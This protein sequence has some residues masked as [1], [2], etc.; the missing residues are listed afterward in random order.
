MKNIKEK[1]YKNFIYP[2]YQ[3]KYGFKVLKTLRHITNTQ[4]LSQEKLLEYQYN[5][6]LKL[7]THAY[8]NVP[9]YKDLMEKIKLEPENIKSLEDLK[10]FPILTKKI[11]REN[12]KKLFSKDI[13]N[14]TTIEASTGGTTGEPLK[15]IRD[16][17]T[18]IWTESCLLRG[19]SW[20]KYK[21]GDAVINFMSAGKPSFLGKIRGRLINNYYFPAFE[22]E[23]ALLKYAKDIKNIKP[24]CMESYA[25]NL[26]RIA[27][28][29]HKNKINNIE[30][31]I[32]LSTGEMLYKHQREFIEG[33]FKGKIYDYYGCNE[34]GS[35]AYECE[36]CKKHISD[37]H[38]VVEITDYN[39][40]SS[41]DS[42][43]EFTITDLDN[44]AM[45]FI[46][47][48]NGDVG[49]ITNDLCKCGR[50]L[51]RIK[52]LEGRKQ[53]FLMTFDGN[54]VPA[55]FFPCRFRNLKGIDQYQIIQ[56]DI[57]NIIL[58]IV[59]NHLYSVAELQSL[60]RVIKEMI[61]GDVNVIV[62]EHNRIKLTN[63]GKNRLVIS[64]IAKELC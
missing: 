44:Y 46:R 13:N 18:L 41:R 53:G 58:K 12:Y 40:N 56:T 21:M 3:Y 49:Q 26:Y 35:L 42:L 15:F 23:D 7:I 52:K 33:Q 28:I 34:V 2:I 17:N 8:H 57:Q 22:K 59:K 4:W 60:I 1:V 32:I 20:A 43:G 5:K 16:E 25:S 10:Y 55:I 11:I 27:V 51:K 29:F 47:Y 38:V 54:Y 39:G 36:Y 9:Y 61:K 63:R 37:E 31:P 6:L 62:E 30:I 64:F 45:P 48:K 14:R 24:I 50:R 19:K